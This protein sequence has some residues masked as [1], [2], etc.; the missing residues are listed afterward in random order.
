MHGDC[1]TRTLQDTCAQNMYVHL[2]QMT[3][4]CVGHINQSGADVSISIGLYVQR[5]A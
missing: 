4:T 2:S 1:L 3:S 5:R